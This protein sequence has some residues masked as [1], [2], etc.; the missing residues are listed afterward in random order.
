[1]TYGEAFDLAKGGLNIARALWDSNVYVTFQEGNIQFNTRPKLVIT[2]D[3][4]TKD[5]VAYSHDSEATDWTIW[6]AP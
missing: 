6:V 5:W 4:V 1:M 2:N 3:G